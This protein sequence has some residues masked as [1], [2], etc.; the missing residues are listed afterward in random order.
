MLLIL[1]QPAIGQPVVGEA[2]VRDQ[3]RHGRGE[4]IAHDFVVIK[5]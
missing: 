5:P 4:G 1:H 2:T 3:L